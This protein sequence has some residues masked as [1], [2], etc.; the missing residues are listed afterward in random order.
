MRSDVDARDSVVDLAVPAG[1]ISAVSLL[2]SAL[3]AGE[4]CPSGETLAEQVSVTG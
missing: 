1:V 4:R 2:V 3:Q